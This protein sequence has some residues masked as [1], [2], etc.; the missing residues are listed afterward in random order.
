VQTIQ[1]NVI[2]SG[3]QTENE[4]VSLLNFVNNSLSV[5]NR[6]TSSNSNMEEL[7]IIE[8]LYSALRKEK[9]NLIGLSQ[10]PEQSSPQSRRKLYHEQESDIHSPGM[11]PFP[12]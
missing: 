12:A 11:S 1:L 9:I 2:E 7:V 4:S 8:N 10:S 6:M 3:I 5:L